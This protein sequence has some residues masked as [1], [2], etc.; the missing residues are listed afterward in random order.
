MSLSCIRRWGIVLLLAQLLI[1]WAPACAMACESQGFV[2]AGASGAGDEAQGAEDC[3]CGMQAMC[4]IAFVSMLPCA[5]PAFAATAM[6][7]AP[8][9]ALF[10][11]LTRYIAPLAEP[12][13]A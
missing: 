12:P 8:D 10:S 5:M 9:V 2:T 13:V 11:L 6:P 7:D 4:H 1:A 3:N